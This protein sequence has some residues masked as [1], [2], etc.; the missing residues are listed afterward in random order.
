MNEM[1]DLNQTHYFEIKIFG[2]F[3]D[4][5][6]RSFEGLQVT[7]LMNGETLI[8]GE[9]KDQAQLFGILI[10]IRDMGMPLL[11]VNNKPSKIGQVIGDSK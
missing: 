5:R 8:S 3:S 9:I 2:H 4:Q 1:T 11:S 6:T 7:H 10:R